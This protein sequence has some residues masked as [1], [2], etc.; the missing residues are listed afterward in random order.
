MRARAYAP[1]N[2]YSN[3]EDGLVD[4]TLEQVKTWVRDARALQDGGASATDAL[5]WVGVPQAWLPLLL[6]AMLPGY[7]ELGEWAAS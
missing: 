4:V 5:V 2:T 6:C 1:I 7:G 3:A